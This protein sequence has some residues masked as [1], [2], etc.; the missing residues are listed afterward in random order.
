M[1]K[2]GK[3]VD[4]GWWM[5]VVMVLVSSCSSEMAPDVLAQCVEWAAE[6]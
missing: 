3:M 6:L 5:V 2:M 1:G 4:G